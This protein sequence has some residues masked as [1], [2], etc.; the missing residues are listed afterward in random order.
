MIVT[1]FLFGSSI[2]WEPCLLYYRRPFFS[3]HCYLSP[4]LTII[5]SRSFSASSNHL[6]LGRSMLLLPSGLLSNIFLT[7]LPMILSYLMSNP[8]QSNPIQ[9]NPIQS[10]PIQS[11][12]IQCNA[13]Q[14]NPIQSIPIFSFLIPVN[15][16]N[17]LYSSRNSWLVLILHMSC[18]IPSAYIILI[19]TLSHVFSLFISISLSHHI[20]VTYPATYFV[21]VLC[22][23]IL[24]S[25]LEGL[26]LN[27]PSP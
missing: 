6:N 5:C 18:S 9:S 19:I 15:V 3:V 8:I 1:Y 17:S 27:L 4:L 11:N 23:W 13:M 22:I 10:N 12:L 20:S 25:L 16:S 2:L 24:T 21:I 7:I 26:I 14:C